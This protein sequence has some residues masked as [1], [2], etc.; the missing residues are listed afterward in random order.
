MAKLELNLTD[1]V[2]S[3]V[4]EK[5]TEAFVIK[6]KLPCNWNLTITDGKLYGV[7][8]VSGEKFEGTMQ[9]FNK[10]IRG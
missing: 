5:V 8:N 4:E 2:E 1:K 7:N 9:E 10:A 3:P 6:D